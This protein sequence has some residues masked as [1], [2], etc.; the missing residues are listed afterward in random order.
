MKGLIVNEEIT[1]VLQTSNN[2]NTWEMN[3][4]SFFELAMFMKKYKMLGCSQINSKFYYY[5]F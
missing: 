1:Q 4:L 2:A 3:E 5:S